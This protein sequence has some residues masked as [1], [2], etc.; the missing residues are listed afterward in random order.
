MIWCNSRATV[1]QAAKLKN[2]LLARVNAFADPNKPVE[3]ATIGKHRIWL[4][5]DIPFK[6]PVR[7]VP[8]LK[9]R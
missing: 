5:M 8:I 7:R 6:E 2:Y 1:E 3:R 4:K 9:E